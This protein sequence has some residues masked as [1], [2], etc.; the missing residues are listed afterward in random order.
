MA[1]VNV[2]RVPV[3]GPR[4]E[5]LRRRRL[6][7]VLGIVAV[8]LLVSAWCAGRANAGDPDGQKF[9]VVVVKQGD[10]LSG[11]AARELP[12]EVNREAVAEIQLANNLPSQHVSAGQ[13]LLIPER[14]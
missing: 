12:Q 11:I 10:S 3:A 9:S 7:F 14:P 5:R 8:A 4:E 13:E 1:V 6:A 2:A